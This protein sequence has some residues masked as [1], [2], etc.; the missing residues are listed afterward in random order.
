M[1]NSARRKCL[2]AKPSVFADPPRC[3]C[4]EWSRRMP[5]F[6]SL[7][8]VLSSSWKTTGASASAAAAV[9]VAAAAAAAGRTHRAGCCCCGTTTRCWLEEEEE[10]EGGGCQFLWDSHLV[11]HRGNKVRQQFSPQNAAGGRGLN[12]GMLKRVALR[13]TSLK[14]ALSHKSR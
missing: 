13:G 8:M 2:H 3:F 11:R 10:V 9:V 12:T 7:K 5:C 6:Y 14:P 4:C 1:R